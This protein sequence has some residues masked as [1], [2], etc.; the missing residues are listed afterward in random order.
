MEGRD[1]RGGRPRVKGE[2][3]KGE[4]ER[5]SAPEKGG[6]WLRGFGRVWV[7]FEA[8]FHSGVRFLCSLV[9]FFKA[10]FSSRNRR[11]K[12]CI[13]IPVAFYLYLVK[14]I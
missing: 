9:C 2:P 1:G 7:A 11:E 10:S 12:H 3:E 8:V 5:E 6:V 4:R 13:R 14:I